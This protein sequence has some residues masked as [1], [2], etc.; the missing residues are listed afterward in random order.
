M[1]VLAMRRRQFLTVFS[2]GL[3]AW[4]FAALAQQLAG[5]KR[6]VGVL[7]GIAKDREGETRLAEFT[8]QLAKLGW[9]D[10]ENVSI[11]D[12]WA[13]GSRDLMK[14][15]AAEL[16]GLAP[17]VIVGASTPVTAALLE[18]TRSIPIVFVVVTDPVGNKFVT[19][20]ARPEGNITG[21][22][23]FEF[24]MGGKWLEILREIA[25]RVARVGIM[26]NPLALPDARSYFG[27]SI[28][29]AGESSK[30]KLIDVAVSNADEI[31]RSIDELA[32]EPNSG[33]V[34]LA[35]NVTVYHRNLIVELAERY[36]LPAVYPYRYFAASGGLLSYGIDT[37]DL[38]RRA[39]SYVDRI[40]RGAK[41][42]DLPVQQPTKFELVINLKAAKALGLTIPRS[43]RR[44][45]EVIE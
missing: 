2:G 12:R 10:G 36:R 23:N 37:V 19:N 31:K 39:A 45:D 43:L 30:I 18:K 16:V 35:D 15:H 25:P 28:E 3:F 7:I 14:A 8:Q 34:V 40:L 22:T 24:S 6:R 26:F 44:A 17:D 27:S 29:A 9:V 41:P 11:I 21:F 4:P 33:L 38:Y 5:A 13:A 20:L 42:A 1:R 32:R